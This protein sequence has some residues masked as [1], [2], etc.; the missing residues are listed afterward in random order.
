MKTKVRKILSLVIIAIVVFGMYV[1]YAGIGSI[2]DLKHSL[3]YGLDINGGV[4]VVMKADTSGIKSSDVKSTMEQTKEVLERRVN[5]MGISEATV[6][7]ENGNRLRIEMPGVKNTKAAIKRIG[8]TAQ[9]KFTLA[10]GTEVLSGS[11]IKNAEAAMDQENGGYKIVLTFTSEGRTKFA[12]ATERAAS[13]K[14]NATVKD[15]DGNSVDSTSIVIWLDDEILTAPTCE[16]K[17]DSDSCEITS[18]AGGYSKNEASTEAALIRGGSLPVSLTEERSSVTS[19][20][21]GA[22]AL[23][24]SIKAGIIGLILVFVLMLIMYN[25]LGLFAD[26]ALMLYVMLVLWIMAAMGGVLTLPGIAGIILGIGMAVDANVVIFSRIKEEIGKGRSIRVAVD[27]GFKHALVTVLDSQI[28]TLIATVILYQLGDTSVKGFALTL[29]ISIIVSIFTAVVITQIFVN[30][31]ADSKNPKLSWFGCKADGTPKKIVKKELHFIENRKK[32]Y[33]VSAAVIITGLVFLGV[34]GFNYGID[35]TGGTMI[36]MN[37]HEKVDIS[38]VEKA[39]DKY[40]LNETITYSGSKK[41]EIVI[42]TTKALKTKERTAVAET[43]E[44]EFGLKSSDVIESSEIGPTVGSGL[45][46][47]AMKSIG[48]AALGMLIYIII[49]FRS[50][51]YGVAAV[52]GILH[53]VLV[54]IAVYAIFGIEVNNP[55]IAVILTIVGYSINDTIVIFDRVRENSRTMRGQP[56]VDILDVSISQ[57]LDRSIMTS[58]TTII[59]IIPL[60]IMVSAYLSEFVLPLMI[61]VVSGTYSSICLCSPLYFEF[62]RKEEADRLKEVEKSK[63]RIEAKRAKKHKKAAAALPEAEEKSAEK[64]EKP[65]ETAAETNASENAEEKTPAK[66]AQKKNQ[67]QNQRKNQSRKSRKSKNKSKKRKRK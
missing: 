1:S 34:K 44:K 56:L 38:K 30:T 59:S 8:Q 22:D 48:L 35:F 37:M 21:I 58:A 39:I 60:L 57:T 27:E 11:D 6:S 32:F 5:A 47:N 20:T 9:L 36:Q 12:S 4:Y 25:M 42:K 54:L 64:A 51:K 7:I 33:V 14:V 10:D 28:T 15:S 26:I 16:S 2:D 63:A 31:L 55:F 45:K 61:G 50:W 3:K 66:N 17:I 49:R 53:D 24:K 43:I 18:G 41:H 62:N 13:G 52:A 19:A 46:K 67:N 29:M 23:D 40:D 65:A